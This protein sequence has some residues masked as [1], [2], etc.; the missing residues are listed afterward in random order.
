VDERK[1]LDLFL[2]VLEANHSNVGALLALLKGRGSN[3]T[4][5]EVDAVQKAVDQHQK[6]LKEVGD[7]I[8]GNK[9]GA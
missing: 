3:A 2:S 1:T 5:A 8:R 6:L 7:L 9:G 4:Q